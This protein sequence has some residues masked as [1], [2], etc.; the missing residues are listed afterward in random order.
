VDDNTRDSSQA[1]FR[2]DGRLAI[3]LAAASA[4]VGPLVAFGLERALIDPSLGPTAAALTDA[5]Q[6]LVGL[7]AGVAVTTFV[8]VFVFFRSTANAFGF[9]AACAL[10]G[11]ALVD[12]PVFAVAADNPTDAV[13]LGL[14]ACPWVAISGAVGAFLGS[15]A[16]TLVKRIRVAHHHGEPE[17]PKRPR[18]PGFPGGRETP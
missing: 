4:A 18:P 7:A 8:F 1:R 16:R 12:L 3:A 9:G 15:A 13:R 2:N 14:L 5:A 10:A 11:F 17:S 6:F